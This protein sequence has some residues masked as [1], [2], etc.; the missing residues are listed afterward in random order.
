VV[1]P[2]F[3][4]SPGAPRVKNFGLFWVIFGPDL[5]SIWIRFWGSLGPGFSGLVERAG[6][7]PKSPYF[8]GFWGLFDSKSLGFVSFEG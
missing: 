6:F 3:Q 8:R 2:T 4:G 7:G 1:N 5:D